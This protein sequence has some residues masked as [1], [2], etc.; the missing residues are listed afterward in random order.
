MSRT[1]DRPGA[2]R[3]DRARAS[4]GGV[5][6]PSGVFAPEQ[7]AEFNGREYFSHLD[8][9]AVEVMRSVGE[10]MQRQP[11]HMVYEVLTLSM[12]RRL[13]GITVDQELMRDAAARIAIGLPPV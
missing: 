7:Q 13:P 12:A 6:S 8:E 10:E 9:F 5:S 1:P 3:G 2:Y 4:I 11:A